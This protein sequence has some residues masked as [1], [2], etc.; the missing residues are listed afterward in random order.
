L[1]LRP[2]DSPLTPQ[3]SGQP[4]LLGSS[5]SSLFLQL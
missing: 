2:I 3:A 5:Q 4:N 1:N